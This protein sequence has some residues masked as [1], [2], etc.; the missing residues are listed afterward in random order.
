M[1]KIKLFTD[2]QKYLDDLEELLPTTEEEFLNDKK[3]QDL[4]AVEQFK[5][6]MIG[7]F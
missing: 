1:K 6:K 5:K 3:A 7:Y 4:R 2:L